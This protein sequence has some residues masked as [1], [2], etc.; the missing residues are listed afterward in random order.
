MISIIIP[1]YNR[2]LILEE[3][4]LKTLSIQTNIEYEII[5]VNDG[6]ALPFAINNPKIS[7]FKNPKKGAASA[8]NYGAA[9]AKYTILFFIDDDMW[10]T[11]ESLNQILYLNQKEILKNDWKEKKQYSSVYFIGNPDWV[12]KKN[13]LLKIQ[14]QKLI[15]RWKKRY[16]EKFKHI[17][18]THKQKNKL[19]LK[20]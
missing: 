8:R 13:A 14:H 10:I 2:F 19:H 20:T 18:L 5:I 12:I 17:L 11:A 6:K 7:L 15:D 16:Q 3:T 1:T 9:Q 4:I